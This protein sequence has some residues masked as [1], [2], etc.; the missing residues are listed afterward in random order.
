MRH[1][2]NLLRDRWL[3]LKK[4]ERAETLKHLL[5]A[6]G[7]QWQITQHQAPITLLHER[8][9]LEYVV[10]LGGE[11]RMGMSDQELEAGLRIKDPFPV[12]VGPMRPAHQVSVQPFLITKY[13]L[14]EAFVL[15]NGMDLGPSAVTADQCGV[16]PAWFPS[17]LTR[18]QADR[19]AAK[20]DALLPSEAQWEYTYRSGS[21][22]LF[23]WGDTVPDDV[24][25]LLCLVT[26]LDD[27]NIRQRHANSFGVVG[28]NYG[29][30]CA[31][32]FCPYNS[33]K[34]PHKP[35]RSFARAVRGGAA[36]YWPWQDCDEWVL[37]MSS[38][39]RGERKA[40]K[41]DK[42]ANCARLVKNI[43]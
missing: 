25:D 41:G 19:I 13:P 20:H 17:Y 28:M 15:A 8:T 4:N 38:T 29:E 37:C 18:L 5:K 32:A 40:V 22:T 34:R 23:P 3:T 6:L 2:K 39:R 21:T 27:A 7:G 36:S 26:D 12:D 24:E 30:W 1:M 14:S 42:E 9:E 11:F 10:V 33:D 35:K 43:V 16:D 31:D